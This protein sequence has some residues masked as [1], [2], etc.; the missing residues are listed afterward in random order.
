MGAVW[1]KAERKG[2]PRNGQQERSKDARTQWSASGS[3]CMRDGSDGG[4]GGD[5]HRGDGVGGGDDGG[6]GG[7]DGDG[8]GGGG[9]GGSG[10]GVHAGSSMSGTASPGGKACPHWNERWRS[11]A[12]KIIRS[13]ISCSLR[14]ST[15]MP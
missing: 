13:G 3:V 14:A 2:R 1:A 7:G 8:G 12:A 15:T 10:G 6:D 5:G 9:D 4:D 11:L